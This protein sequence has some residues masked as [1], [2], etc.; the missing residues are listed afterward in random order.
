MSTG[1]R[2]NSNSDSLLA[3][4]F[5]DFQRRLWCAGSDLSELRLWESAPTSKMTAFRSKSDAYSEGSKE[6]LLLKK[7]KKRWTYIRLIGLEWE[8]K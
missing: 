5:L 3:A 6:Q 4:R 1:F 8:L 2:F 7:K